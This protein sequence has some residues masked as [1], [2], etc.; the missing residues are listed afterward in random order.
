MSLQTIVARENNPLE[1]LVVTIG[2]IH[3]GTQGNIIP[4]QVRM[5]L[6]VRTFSED[7]RQRALSSIERIAKAEA[8]AAGAPREPTIEFANAGIG[9]V[10]N[11]PSLT[12]RLAT[13]LRTAM[14][15]DRV[16]DMP[17]KMTSE[18]FA[19]Y[20]RA[21]VPA[22]LLHI[23]AVAPARL[24]EARRTGNPVPAPHSPEWLPALEPTLK[25]AVQAETAA[26]IEL[27]Q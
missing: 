9:P 7:V 3:G 18:D 15:P 5:E 12:G 8:L 24:E 26:L 21:G 20:G 23:G 17:A 16:V 13:A 19:E 22:V 10:F 14:G 25:G 11:D 6:S 27:L 4:D 1:P 2:S